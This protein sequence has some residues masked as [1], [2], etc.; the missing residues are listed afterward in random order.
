M[1]PYQQLQTDLQPW[2]PT[3]GKAVDTILDQEVSKYPLF[4]VYKGDIAIGL[5]LVEREGEEWSI[6]ASTLEEFATKG[7]IE[8]DKVDNFKEVYKDPLEFICLFVVNPQGATFVF[9]PRT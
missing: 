8:P 5:P 9:L 4:V 1:N 2:I 6:N 7:L 3:L